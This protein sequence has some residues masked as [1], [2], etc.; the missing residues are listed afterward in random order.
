[1]TNYDRI[2]QMNIEE[3]SIMLDNFRLDCTY[4]PASNFCNE[5]FKD[6]KCSNIVKQWL[7][8]EVEE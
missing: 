4:C 3:M 2:K 1:M 5:S 7:E 8:M 6:E